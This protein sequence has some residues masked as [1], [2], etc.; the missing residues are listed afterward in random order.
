MCRAGR[1][2]GRLPEVTAAVE[3][4]ETDEQLVLS[5]SG[6]QAKSRLRGGSDHTD[7]TVVDALAAD[8]RAAYVDDGG[9]PR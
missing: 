3:A 7:T 1:Q 4:F 8:C 9:N 5:V 2:R 6:R